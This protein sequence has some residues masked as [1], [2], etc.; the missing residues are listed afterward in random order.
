MNGTQQ[1][2]QQA[3]AQSPQILLVDDEPS[4]GR[5]LKMV[6]TEEGYSVDLAMTGLNALDTFGSKDFDLV[7]ADLRLP[8]MDG[9]DV[10]KHVKEK[11][12]DVGVI[13]ITGYS[14]VSS[15][16]GAMKMGA[17]DYMPKPFTADEFRDS[18]QGA[19]RQRQEL[20][21]KRILEAEEA[22]LIEKREV[23]LVL[24]RAV[25]EE[26][27]WKDLMERGSEALE[28]FRL[29][30]EAKAAVVSGDLNWIR[31]HLGDLNERQF[32]WIRSRLELE[33][34]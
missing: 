4:L 27:F 13:V 17:F 24:E 29:S 2:T 5:G 20:L 30:S 21:R 1:I 15:A 16:V 7:V 22:K 8:D 12:P 33:R 14:T 9:M 23:A 28:G 32:L 25:E 26:A 19:L 3:F 10:I 34:W 11:R 18:V 6:L 31:R